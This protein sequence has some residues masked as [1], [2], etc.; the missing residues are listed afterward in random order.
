MRLL[1][2]FLAVCC[3][4]LH[5]QDAWDYS[6]YLG[7][8]GD[9]LAS[10]IAVDAAGNTYVAGTA[11]SIGFPFAPSETP[12]Y[13][14]FTYN[15]FLIKL[16]PD[17]TLLFAKTIV[18]G[19]VNAMLVD[20]EGY[21]YL[22]GQTTRPG[23]ETTPGSFVTASGVGAGGTF[24]MKT[25]PGGDTL[26]SSYVAGNG[27][28]A[29]TIAVDASRNVIVCGQARPNFITLTES[30]LQ[31]PG[32]A[33]QSLAGFCSQ[34]SADGSRLLFA[35]LLGGSG[36]TAPLASVIGSQGKLVVTGST[37]STDFPL[38][39]AYQD[40][41]ARKTL[42]RLD[43]GAQAWTAVGDRSLGAVQS[44]QFVPDSKR[45]LVAS[46]SGV[47]A[48]DYE[49]GNLQ[50]LP[51]FGRSIVVHPRNAQYI[52]ASTSS[53]Q[54]LCSTD[55]GQ[56]W[57]FKV[58]SGI[59]Q[60]LADPKIEGGFYLATDQRLQYLQ[61]A[62][63]GF[64]NLDS[65]VPVR[66][67]AIDASGERTVLWAGN[68][69]SFYRS[70]DGGAGFERLNGAFSRFEVAPNAPN[71]LYALRSSR[72]PGQ[73]LLA[74]SRDGG[75]T[76]SDIGAGFEPRFIQSIAI[77]PQSASIVY[78]ATL[79]GVF[80]SEDSG[81]TWSLLDVGL[82]N[83]ALQTLQFDGAGNLWAGAA[84]GNQGF[85]L[86]LNLEQAAIEFSTW[87]GGSGGA[88]AALGNQGFVLKL[89]LEQAA[90][91]FSTWLGGSGGAAAV[92]PIAREDGRVTV[93]GRTLSSDFPV[94]VKD[95]PAGNPYS[96][97]FMTVFDSSGQLESS[98]LLG[99]SGAAMTLDAAG[100]LHVA[101]SGTG[102]EVFGADV[103]VNGTFRGGTS[104]G[105]WTTIDLDTGKLIEATWIGGSGADTLTGIAIGKDRKVRLTG[106]T[107][108]SDF[109][110]TS[111]AVQTQSGGQ[112]DS[113]LT[114]TRLP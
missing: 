105:L 88:A 85:V 81:Q 21:A 8:L 80:R 102:T 46:D 47:L 100:R 49:G 33:T 16:A 63:S 97:M 86:K 89:N 52:C 108:S 18:S 40:T 43:R 41:D 109:P 90:I 106:T 27:S 12:G 83:G 69:S 103:R 11:S 113:F 74:R 50:P 65:P 114:V 13:Y 22:A 5:G 6:T 51:A 95:R 26:F 45:I 58:F 23:F 78:I 28:S 92:W 35:T 84:L 73:P 104:D 10:L 14:D 112:T 55:G 56:T 79:D 77:D 30:A 44:I 96:Q 15:S 99:P 36:V 57:S 76:W 68:G 67:M 66:W 1:F 101:G 111:G 93:L 7:G 31:K 110:V 2:L 59:N 24:A 71:I 37:G 29:S 60:V 34:L 32:S 98:R 3:A 87:L 25:A 54:L 62:D 42:F 70:V 107:T 94:T 91:E 72:T 82:T 4:L 9:D 48:S 17:G 75:T 38:K 61:L 39:N 20:S 53:R 19:R 64:R